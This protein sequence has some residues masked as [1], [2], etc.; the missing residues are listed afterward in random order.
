MSGGLVTGGLVSRRACGRR[1]FVLHSFS[2]VTLRA[3]A[4]EASGSGE[5]SGNAVG[6]KS[7][8]DR[9]QFFSLSDDS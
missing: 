5:S 9:G 1:A 2:T 4:V 6:L 8:L 7:I 3:S